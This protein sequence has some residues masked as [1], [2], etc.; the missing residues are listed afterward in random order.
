MLHFFSRLVVQRLFTCAIQQL[1]LVYKNEHQNM[2][3]FFRQ[4][5]DIFSETTPL[6]NTKQDQKVFRSQRL[7][8]DFMLQQ[9]H[10]SKQE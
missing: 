10:I 2:L 6:I 8:Q 9:N 4:K 5:K 7:C 1:I 3:V